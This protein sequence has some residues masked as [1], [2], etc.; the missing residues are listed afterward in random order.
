MIYGVD[1]VHGHGNLFGAT[2][3]PHNVGLGAT[4]DPKLVQD[5]E[6]MVATE[7]RATGIPWVFAPCLCVARDDRWG[8]TYET[9][10]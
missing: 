2:L 10:R 5:A 9:L 4:R 1:S 8:R 3:I 7:T 6:Q